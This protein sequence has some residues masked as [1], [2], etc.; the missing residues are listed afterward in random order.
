MILTKLVI[1]RGKETKVSELKPQSAKMVLVECPIC[2]KQRYANYSR[3]KY[4]QRCHL[5]ALKSMTKFLPTGNKYNRYTVINNGLKIGKSLCQCD[6]G[7]IKEIDNYELT[8]GHTKSC[9]CFKSEKASYNLQM[10]TKNQKKENHPMW[11]GGI[12]SERNIFN[13]QK[14]TKDWRQHIYERDNYTCQSCGQIGYKLNVHHIQSYLEYSELRLTLNN[15]ITLCEN[16]HR[17][18]HKL[19]GRKNIGI[20]QIN[21]FLLRQKN[22]LEEVLV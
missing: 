13:A 21:K 14:E 22:P 4:N 18:F 3:I 19:F 17:Q 10:T 12:S 5:C 16:C 6:C 20:E 1:Y 15:G 2:K 11:K 9:G 8:S 7:T